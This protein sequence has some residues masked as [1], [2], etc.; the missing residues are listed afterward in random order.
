ML[1]CIGTLI[2]TH[3]AWSMDWGNSKKGY[4]EIPSPEEEKHHPYCWTDSCVKTT[5]EGEDAQTLRNLGNIQE[6]PQ[7][8]QGSVFVEVMLE[9]KSGLMARDTKVCEL[10]KHNKDNDPLSVA[11]SAPAQTN[12]LESKK[13]AVTIQ[14]VAFSNDSA[15]VRYYLNTGREISTRTVSVNFNQTD[16]TPLGNGLIITIAAHLAS[17]K[18]DVTTRRK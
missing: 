2:S 10:A 3:S 13:P 18:S 11:L 15:I 17:S 6:Q 1:F 5:E 8:L 7:D 4:T 12:D 16:K 14:Q 9:N